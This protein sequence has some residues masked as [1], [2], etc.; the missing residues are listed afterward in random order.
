MIGHLLM[1]D[2][3]IFKVSAQTQKSFLGY[4]IEDENFVCADK[5]KCY[6]VP[7]IMLQILNSDIKRIKLA[8]SITEGSRKKAAELLNVSEMTIYRINK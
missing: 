2:E 4:D 8:L 7:D 6:P 5:T 3:S 1:T